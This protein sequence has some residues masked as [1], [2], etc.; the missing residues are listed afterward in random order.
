[1]YNYLRKPHNSLNAFEIKNPIQLIT[2]KC[3]GCLNRVIRSKYSK[4]FS[5]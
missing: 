1:M 4:M 2:L 3:G 5:L